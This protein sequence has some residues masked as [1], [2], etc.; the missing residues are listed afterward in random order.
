VIASHIRDRIKSER[1]GQMLP[2]IAQALG[3]SLH[4]STPVTEDPF[5]V[6]VA[7]MLSHRTKEDITM[8][9]ARRLF[10]IAPTPELL[11]CTS[12]RTIEKKIYPVGM[13]RTKARALKDMALQLASTWSGVVPESVNDLTN[14]RGVGRKTATMVA[15]KGYGQCEICVDTHVH[16]V[17]NRIGVVATDSPEATVF[18]LKKV[19]PREYWIGYNELLVDF[20]RKTCRPL[21]PLCS[22][23]P[24]E[25]HCPKVGV[26]GRH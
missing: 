11:A 21:S 6:L 10:A 12:V 4:Q 3:R 24:L 25:Y 18:G 2:I 15:I 19:L 22:Q 23:C 8:E 13:Y 5:W 17:S 1:V 9:A 7:T 20:G 26:I 16:R 14:I